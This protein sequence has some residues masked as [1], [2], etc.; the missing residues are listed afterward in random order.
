MASLEEIESA[1]KQMDAAHEDLMRYIEGGV[2]DSQMHK[3]LAA[4]LKAAVDKSMNR[5]TQG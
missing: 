1:K 2:M 4:R 5:I 3:R